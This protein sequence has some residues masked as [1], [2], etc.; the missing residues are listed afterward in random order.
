LTH[1]QPNEPHVPTRW[2]LA[3]AHRSSCEVPS[4]H[5][6]AHTHTHISVRDANACLALSPNPTRGGPDFRGPTVVR[7]GCFTPF[8]LPCDP[9]ERLHAV[10][11]CGEFRAGGCLVSS[12][13][14]A[15]FAD[16]CLVP[17]RPHVTL[18]PRGA[19]RDAP[20]RP[21]DPECRVLESLLITPRTRRVLSPSR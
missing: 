13:A 18:T 5:T 6:D 19:V 2:Y 8:R 17:P 9:I 12:A 1:G 16:T 21:C 10:C 14:F 7:P 20:F 11:S 3:L 4:T 15:F